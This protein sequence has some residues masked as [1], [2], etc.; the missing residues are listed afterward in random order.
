MK[1]NYP[2]ILHHKYSLEDGHVTEQVTSVEGYRGII[3]ANKS[4]EQ[5]NQ[6]PF[7]SVLS[8]KT[9]KE[10]PDLL[11]QA[12]VAAVHIHHGS[13]APKFEFLKEKYG[14][15]LFVSFRG[16][17][18]TAYPKKKGNL[19]RLKKLFRTADLFFPVCE[20]LKQEIIRLGCHEDK[21]RVLYGGIDLNRFE[22]RPRIVDSKKKIRF[23]AIGRFVEKKGFANLIRAFAKVKKSYTQVE[24]ILIGRG[25]LEEEYR[26]LIKKLEL[27]SSVEIVPWVD[28]R[29]I[30]KK[31][32]RS[33]IFCAPSCTDQNGNQEGIPNTL[34]EAMATGMPVI[35]SIHAGIPELV[36][37][38]VS[39]LLVPEGSVDE[40][41]KA[42][43]WL[44]KHPE[45][46][47]NL[48]VNAR[49]KVETDFNL[50]LQLKRQKEYY[51]EVLINR[52]E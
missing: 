42:M 16:N 27:G 43:K 8:L 31:Y 20:H 22:C 13:L 35:A 2:S 29:K 51:D 21:I 23:L 5:P 44:I 32:Y 28:Y 41:A 12:N 18:A 19:K 52:M 14:I 3:I 4:K 34:T 39:G 36:K 24:L 9:I 46:W 38:K 1:Q 25:P 50:P 49:K 11:K 33:H 47:E 30:E 40:L 17:D 37:D 48:G 10:N 7:S 45:K 26:K 6:T 15:P